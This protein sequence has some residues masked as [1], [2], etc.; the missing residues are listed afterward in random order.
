ML[1][2]YPSANRDESVFQD[3]MTFDISRPDVDKLLSFGLGMHY[4]LG[5]QVAR[6]ELRTMLNKV[7]ERVQTIE[8]DGEPQYSGAHF[9]GGV[10]H[11]PIRYTMR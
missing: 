8:L 3:P 7:L 11:L 10:K 6:R 2:S 5:A 4:C 1:T 9:V